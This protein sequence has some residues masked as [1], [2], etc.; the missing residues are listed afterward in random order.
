MKLVAVVTVALLGCANEDPLV[1]RASAWATSNGQQVTVGAYVFDSNAEGNHLREIVLEDDERIVATFRGEQHEMVEVDDTVNGTLFPP[2]HHEVTFPAT[3]TAEESIRVEITNGTA[4]DDVIIPLAFTLSMP[5]LPKVTLPL[6]VV[7][8]PAPERMRW[9][10]RGADA[11]ETS[12]PLSGGWTEV[13]RG[14]DETLVDEGS[15]TIEDLQFE[16]DCMLTLVVERYR[17]TG[18]QQ[19]AVSFLAAAWR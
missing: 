10:V 19:R 9:Q 7:W 14:N 11:C 2:Y 1:P 6:T 17:A 16:S 8:E 18:V 13:V 4:Y 15:L 3:V 5:T 12:Y